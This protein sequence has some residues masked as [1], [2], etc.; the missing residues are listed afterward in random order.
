MRV[1][2]R[3]LLSASDDGGC[4]LWRPAHLIAPNDLEQA[5]E[6][7]VLEGTGGGVRALH[8]EGEHAF[9]A[10]MHGAVTCWDVH[11]GVAVAPRAAAWRGPAFTERRV[12][13]GATRVSTAGPWFY[14]AWF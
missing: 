3:A 10:G 5:T 12:L 6:T 11:A 8:A 7:R 1:R 9:A 2:G 13:E 14:G 4:R